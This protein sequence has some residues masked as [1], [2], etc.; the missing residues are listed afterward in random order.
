MRLPFFCKSKQKSWLWQETKPKFFSHHAISLTV[1]APMV[2]HHEEA[3]LNVMT[4][5][6]CLSHISS[7]LYGLTNFISD[8]HAQHFHDF[9]YRG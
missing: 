2:S 1:T 7:Y 9:L 6:L 8:F 5:N 4:I 3:R